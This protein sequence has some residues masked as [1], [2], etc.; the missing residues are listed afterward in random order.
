MQKLEQQSS[1]G[2][3]IGSVERMLT[4]LGGGLMV[5]YGLRQGK[6]GIPLVLMGGA[7]AV[8]GISGRSPVYRALGVNRAGDQVSEITHAMTIAAE[9]DALY[10]I[11]RDLAGLPRFM[12]HIASVSV[13]D[14]R[15][16]RWVAQGPAGKT[17]EWE[18]ELI[19]DQA[20]NLIAWRAL[21]DQTSLWNAGQVE[22]QPAPGERG[23]EVR[24]T[25]TYQ[26]PAG[27]LGRL[28]AAAAG[29]EPSL[30]VL[31][32]LRRLKMWQEAGEI[33]T[34]AMR[35]DQN[36]EQGRQPWQR[37]SDQAQPDQSKEV[38]A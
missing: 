10:R 7:I 32:S 8:R 1:P 4:A 9:P 34:G 29:Q 6:R 19:E 36:W 3:N 20:P 17:I 2:P 31:D 14:E 35:R 18:A 28:V 22:F 37:E 33:A 38:G 11:W 27:G 26:A 5:A 13:L 15:R 25:M 16:S 23:T 21:P 12:P 30:L 24:V